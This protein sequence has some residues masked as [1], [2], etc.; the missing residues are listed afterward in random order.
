MWVG[1]GELEQEVKK[2]IGNKGLDNAVIS[3]GNQTD[4]KA[5]YSAMDLL[6]LAFIRL[7]KMIYNIAIDHDCFF[8]H[9]HVT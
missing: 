9:I 6:Q 1:T 3:M 2:Y 5:M 7:L 8:C 4:M